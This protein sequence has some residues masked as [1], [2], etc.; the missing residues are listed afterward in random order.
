MVLWLAI[1]LSKK[2][3]KR[4]ERN[5]RAGLFV[6]GARSATSNWRSVCQRS[7]IPR[8]KL[9]ASADGIVSVS[10]IAPLIQGYRRMPRVT[11]DWAGRPLAMTECTRLHIAFGFAS[12]RL[13]YPLCEPFA[14]APPPIQFSKTPAKWMCMPVRLWRRGLAAERG[15]ARSRIGPLP[16]KAT[17]RPARAATG[18][19]GKIGTSVV[20]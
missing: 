1:Q 4:E 10:I 16:Y 12:K 6:F 17:T 14:P 9:E 5:R 7:D 11:P 19:Q 20:V 15:R 13:T 8:E 18:V 3:E 2:E